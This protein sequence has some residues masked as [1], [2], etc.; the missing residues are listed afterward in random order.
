MKKALSLILALIMCLSLCACGGNGENN[1]T[2]PTPTVTITD[3]T[4]DTTDTI[5]RDYFG[6]AYLGL[7]KS[8]WEMT[9][10]VDEFGDVSANSE[11]A[12]RTEIAGDFS[13]TATAKSDLKGYVFVTQ[14]EEGYIITFRLLEYGDHQVTYTSGEAKNIVLK[15][16]IDDKIGE[17]QLQGL[18]P[19]GDLYLTTSRENTHDDLLE[20]LRHG[21]DIR[22]I[23]YIGSSQYN[24]TISSVGFVDACI[25]ADYLSEEWFAGKTATT[26]LLDYELQLG[27]NGSAVFTDYFYDDQGRITKT[28]INQGTETVTIYKYNNQGQ[29]EETIATTSSDGIVYKIETSVYNEDATIVNITSTNGNGGQVKHYQDTISYDEKGNVVS[30]IRIDT[31]TGKEEY[32]RQYSYTYDASGNILTEELSYSNPYTSGTMT[33]QYQYDKDGKRLYAD[34]S[35]GVRYIYGYLV[36]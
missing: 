14:Y 10:T 33:Y 17:Y 22:C 29:L 28:I 12:L 30:L 18:A 26:S 2:E 16:K 36:R 9:K 31:D 11:T 7:G 25:E 5:T 34:M 27:Q 32:R 35:Q 6:P 21:F 3:D 23:I 8:D 24:F 19:N 4:T 15:Y 1:N 13:N 20:F